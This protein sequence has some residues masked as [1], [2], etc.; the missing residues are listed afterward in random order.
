VFNLIVSIGFTWTDL[1]QRAQEKRE[2]L[3]GAN[4]SSGDLIWYRFLMFEIK[5][6]L[7]IEFC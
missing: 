6:L 7:A 5:V 2:H 3:N 4:K 1:S